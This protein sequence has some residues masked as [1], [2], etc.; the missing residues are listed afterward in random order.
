LGEVEEE[1]YADLEQRLYLALCLSGA[2]CA[3]M[4]AGDELTV[5]DPRWR[6]HR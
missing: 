1:R 2:P 5:L 6:T 4:T 3:R